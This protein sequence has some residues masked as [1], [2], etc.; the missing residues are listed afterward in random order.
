MMR[1]LRGGQDQFSI[2]GE[3]L[4]VE[5]P[6]V[7][8][9]TWQPDWPEPQTV[10]QFNLREEGGITTVRVTHSGFNAEFPPSRYEGW[11]RLLGAL[12]GHVERGA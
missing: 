3:Y 7:L 1:G 10:V 6:R 4:A 8:E 12:R 11:R 5:R 9:F 2:R